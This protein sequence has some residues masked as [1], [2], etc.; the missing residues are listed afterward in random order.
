MYVCIYICVW[1]KSYLT[2]RRQYTE[3]KQENDRNNL[4]I[5]HRSS[6]KDIKQGV[7]QRS[8][9]GPLLFFVICK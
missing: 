7:P 4:V 2:K 6:P 5:C 9:L 1:F 8:V 3:I